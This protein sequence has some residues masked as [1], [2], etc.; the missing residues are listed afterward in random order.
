MSLQKRTESVEIY[1]PAGIEE[2]ITAN[3]KVL[4]VRLPFPVFITIVNEGT[5]VIEKDYQ[6]KC[7][8]AQHGVPAFSY[9]F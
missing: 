3:I 6:V 5:V 8:D 4:N 1:G 2:F 7:C 9:C